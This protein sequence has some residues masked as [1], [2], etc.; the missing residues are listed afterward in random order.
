MVEDVS[1]RLSVH[2]AVCAERYTTIVSRIGRL[3]MIIVCAAGA[4]LVG[5]AGL[6]VTLVV[7]G[8]S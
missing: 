2:E 4:L 5:M 8:G 1:T 7:K 6:I 3:E